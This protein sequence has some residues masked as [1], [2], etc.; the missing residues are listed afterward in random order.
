[1]FVHYSKSH[2]NHNWK[3]ERD[4]E[5]GRCYMAAT[6]F[7]N[8][9]WIL[10]DCKDPS[11]SS[12]NLLVLPEASRNPVTLPSNVDMLLILRL[13][14]ASRSSSPYDALVNAIIIPSF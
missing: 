10:L 14:S 11:S 12:P 3:Y 8:A 4:S 5:I 2:I 13:S 1:M 6:R 7:F 9:T